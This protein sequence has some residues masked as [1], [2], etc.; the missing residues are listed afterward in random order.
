MAIL[1][2]D[3]AR[4]TFFDEGRGEP[5]VLV[6]GSASDYRIWEG[7]REQLAAH[8][9]LI[10][11]SRR[12]HWPNAPVPQGV[13]YS[14]REQLDDLQ[15]L[16]RSLDAVPAHLVGHSSGALLCLALA[17]EAPELVRSLGLAEPPIVTLFVSD[18]PKPLELVKLAA[19]HPRTAV[20][21]IRFGVKGIMPARKAFE[22]GHPEAGTR[23]FGDAVLGP[24]GYDRLPEAR[25]AQ[26]RDNIRNLEADVLS[27]EHLP[28]N[29]REVRRVRVPTLIV[30]GQQS[31]PLFHRLADHLEELLPDATQVQIPGASHAMQEDNPSAFNAAVLSHAL[32]QRRAA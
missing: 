8:S 19:T 5:V 18:P 29:E 32:E 28:L 17:M 15:R 27:S 4:L 24:G 30:T 14:M 3:G 6:H 16:L 11:Y 26:V 22:A 12:Y 23:A 20:A 13:D 21:I 2:I 25:R 7:Q 1:D 31:I 9:R 10:T